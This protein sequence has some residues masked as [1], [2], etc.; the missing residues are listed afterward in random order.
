[1]SSK[2]VKVAKFLN[3]EAAERRSPGVVAR[4]WTWISPASVS[5]ARLA[6]VQADGAKS[7]V[8]ATMI[9][10]FPRRMNT[11]SSNMHAS[12]MG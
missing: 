6:Y 7:S 11:A 3:S 12:S 2:A 8:V 4:R 1:M 5:C 9:A 10:E